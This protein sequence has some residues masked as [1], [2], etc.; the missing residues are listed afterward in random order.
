M[1]CS[2]PEARDGE[3]DREARIP[4]SDVPTWVNGGKPDNL[5]RDA[6]RPARKELHERA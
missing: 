6:D 1:R 2:P 5:T 4:E 3:L